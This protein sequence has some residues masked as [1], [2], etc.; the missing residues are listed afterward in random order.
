MK[1]NIYFWIGIVFILGVLVA[2]FFI[3]SDY[4][5]AEITD[6]G[7]VNTDDGRQPIE[8]CFVKFGEK[9]ASGFYDKFTL[10]MSLDGDKVSGYLKILPAEKDSS[11]GSYEGTV[12]AVDPYA[13][14]R[15]IDA[16]WTREGEGMISKEQLRIIF[17]EGTANI[18]FGAMKENPDGSYSYEDLEKVDY[19]L[20]LTDYSCADLTEREEVENILWNNINTLSPVSAVLGGRFY[21]VS[22]DLDLANNSG[23]VVYE[24]G[25]IQEKR[26]FTYE[27][28]DAKVVNLKIK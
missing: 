11:F 10:R 7:V 22:M 19:S 14:A 21:V 18:G 24:D 9:Q 6:D 1:N 13:M 25:H 2:S 26:E 3:N 20:A 28:A 17:G 4:K 5:V 12:S 15:T 23:V 16:V 27:V 8:L